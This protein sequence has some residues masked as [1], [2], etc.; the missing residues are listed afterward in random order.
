VKFY[1][2]NTFYKKRS[3]RYPAHPKTQDFNIPEFFNKNNRGEDFVIYDVNK[4]RLDGRLLMFST[5][6]LLSALFNSDIILCDGTF[7]SRPLLFQ[8]IYVFMGR[9]HGESKYRSLKRRS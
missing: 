3:R 9:Y 5:P 2:A 8:Q 7:K 6:K 4:E 1:S